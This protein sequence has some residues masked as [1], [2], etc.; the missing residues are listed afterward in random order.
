M[1][2]W[3]TPSKCA[4]PAPIRFY[5]ILLG[6]EIN[7][8]LAFRELAYDLTIDENGGDYHVCTSNHSQS[9]A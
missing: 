6:V 4:Y 5:Y 3:R 7:F 8:S 9:K 2:R 1:A